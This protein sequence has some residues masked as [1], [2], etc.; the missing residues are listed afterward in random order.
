MEKT[1][2]PGARSIVGL[3]IRRNKLI[4]FCLIA[5]VLLSALAFS[6]P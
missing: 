6:L 2:L 1:G 3:F 4:L 5:A